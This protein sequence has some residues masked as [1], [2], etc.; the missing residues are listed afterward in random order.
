MSLISWANLKD[1]CFVVGVMHKLGAQKL[2]F[3][4]LLS[5]GMLSTDFFKKNDN[6]MKTARMCWFY[7]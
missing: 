6:L 4:I 1:M 3:P 7:L 5:V 2:L